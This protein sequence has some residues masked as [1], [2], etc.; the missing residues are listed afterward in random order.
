MRLQFSW[1]QSFSAVQKI[2]FNFDK[3]SLLLLSDQAFSEKHN[4]NLQIPFRLSA[5]T[6]PVVEWKLWQSSH[7][8]AFP[9]RPK[10]WH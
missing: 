10:I 1:L 8:R 5:G 3:H 2:I 7:E 6:G 9:A 4:E